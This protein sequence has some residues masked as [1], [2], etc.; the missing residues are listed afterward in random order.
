MTRAASLGRGRDLGQCVD[1]WGGSSAVENC[2]ISLATSPLGAIEASGP[3]PLEGPPFEGLGWAM[4]P[5]LR[6][7]CAK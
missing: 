6:A 5:L 2:Q 1:A 3:W 4:A 7:V